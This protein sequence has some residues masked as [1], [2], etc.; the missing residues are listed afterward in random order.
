M[1]RPQETFGSHMKKWKVWQPR[2][3]RLVCADWLDAGS[4]LVCSE[5]LRWFQVASRIAGLYLLHQ[6]SDTSL[7]VLS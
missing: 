4:F 7:L 3:P 5:L 1:V 2:P 6:I